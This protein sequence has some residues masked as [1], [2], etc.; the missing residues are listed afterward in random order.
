MTNLIPIIAKTLLIVGVG[1]LHGC[2]TDYLISQPNGLAPTKMITW[3]RA[4]NMEEARTLCKDRYPQLFKSQHRPL[5]C[6]WE[7]S[8]G[9]HVV[10]IDSEFH[11][12]TLG[13]EVK[14]CFHGLWHDEQRKPKPGAFLSQP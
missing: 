11:L 2:A 1:I 4:A 8:T 10:S 14:H 5:G 12:R 13:H 6:F 3:H 7:T 9:C